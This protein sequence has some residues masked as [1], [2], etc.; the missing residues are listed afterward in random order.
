MNTISMILIIVLAGYM[1]IVYGIYPLYHPMQ[2]RILTVLG[3]A[4][5]ICGHSVLLNDANA[6]IYVGDMMKL[7]GALI[8]WFGATGILSSNKSIVSK[9]RE[10][11]LE[12]IDA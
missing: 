1:M 7:F 6:S 4:S 10:Q 9:K 5:I 2:K 8:I 3:L 12:I 11:S